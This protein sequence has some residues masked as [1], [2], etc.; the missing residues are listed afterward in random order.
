MCAIA[1]HDTKLATSIRDTDIMEALTQ[2]SR[3][4]RRLKGYGS[5]SVTPR[6][7]RRRIFWILNLWTVL[8]YPGQ[9]LF[10]K[11][12]RADTTARAP[13]YLDV[14]TSEVCVVFTKVIGSVPYPLQKII[15]MCVSKPVLRRRALRSFIFLSSSFSS[16]LSSLSLVY[17]VPSVLL[18]TINEIC[19]LVFSCSAARRW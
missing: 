2:V 5:L 12:A 10:P 9:A 4:L 18:P 1:R 19:S 15:F 17:A 6:M 11:L 13:S 16:F 14:S 3:P 7:T 8:P